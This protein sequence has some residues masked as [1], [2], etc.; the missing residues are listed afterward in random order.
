MSGPMQTLRN[1]FANAVLRQT[2]AQLSEQLFG[3]VP[4]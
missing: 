2:P 1:E 4:F 3:V